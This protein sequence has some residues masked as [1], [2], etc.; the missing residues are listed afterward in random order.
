MA[1]RIQRVPIDDIASTSHDAATM[2]WRGWIAQTADRAPAASA[3]A[4]ST[5][6]TDT[7]TRQAPSGGN[8][9]SPATNSYGSSR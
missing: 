6:A 9:I 8:S 1:G 5:G 2:V 3:I 4:A 7:A